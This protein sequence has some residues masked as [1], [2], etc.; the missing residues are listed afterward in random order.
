LIILY[1]THV[2]N[3]RTERLFTSCHQCFL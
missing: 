3:S 1:T 2:L